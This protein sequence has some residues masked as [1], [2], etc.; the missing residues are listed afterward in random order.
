MDV[1]PRS[2]AAM[3]SRGSPAQISSTRPSETTAHTSPFCA[4]SRLPSDAHSRGLGSVTGMP[5]AFSAPASR[6]QSAELSPLGQGGTVS[7]TALTTGFQLPGMASASVSTRRSPTLP[8]ARTSMSPVTG[9]W[10]ISASRHSASPA[11]RTS[12]RHFPQVPRPPQGA[13]ASSPAAIRA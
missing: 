7:R 4:V 6:V 10:H 11:P 1:V 8:A 3:Y 9:V 12:Q 13:S 5:A 2:K